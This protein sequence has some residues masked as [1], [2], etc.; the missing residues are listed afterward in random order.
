MG[1][2]FPDARSLY[3]PAYTNVSDSHPIRA[4][5]VVGA[6]AIFRN[7]V[8][9]TWAGLSRSG[10][11]ARLRWKLNRASSPLSGPA[12][13]LL[14]YRVGRPCLICSLH[15]LRDCDRHSIPDPRLHVEGGLARDRPWLS[16]GRQHPAFSTVFR[17]SKLRRPRRRGFSRALSV[18]KCVPR[19]SQAPARRCHAAALLPILAWSEQSILREADCPASS[20]QARRNSRCPAQ[21]GA[22]CQHQP[23]VYTAQRG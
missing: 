1:S 2:T 4:R 3:R 6:V 9:T 21:H 10:A 16:K 19:A 23:V 17:A 13:S 8:D 11:S 14:R 22:G 7:A 20:A 5:E 18:G 12:P 15:G